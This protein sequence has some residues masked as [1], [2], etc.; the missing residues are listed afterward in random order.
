MVLRS[1]NDMRSRRWYAGGPRSSFVLIELAR[2]VNIEVTQW[3]G[4]TIA[5]LHRDV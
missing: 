5:A 1:P 4:V 2:H 3:S